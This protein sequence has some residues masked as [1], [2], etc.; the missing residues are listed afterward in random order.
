MSEAL[1]SAFTATAGPSSVAAWAAAADTTG[2]SFVPVTSHDTEA[3]VVAVPSLTPYASVTVRGSPS[4]R[5]WYSAADG[6]S[7]KLWLA[8]S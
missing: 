1:A 6:S 7:V 5:T 8:A 4:A 2:A 3:G